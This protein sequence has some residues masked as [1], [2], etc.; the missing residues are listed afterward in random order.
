MVFF[1]SSPN[2]ATF[3]H[4]NPTLERIL[5]SAP[6]RVKGVNLGTCQREMTKSPGSLVSFYVLPSFVPFFWTLFSL[7]ENTQVEMV[8]NHQIHFQHL[9]TKVYNHSSTTFTRA[10]LKSKTCTAFRDDKVKNVNIEQG[11]IKIWKDAVNIHPNPITSTCHLLQKLLSAWSIWL[12]PSKRKLK[13][14]FKHI[15]YGDIHVRTTKLYYQSKSNQLNIHNAFTYS[16]WP[17]HR[18][19]LYQWNGNMF[20]WQ[21][22]RW[23]LCNI[24]LWPWNSTT[25]FQ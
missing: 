10:K 2:F 1:V 22:E 15:L 25:W 23:G 7:R 6:W 17:Q 13:G 21:S 16:N 14:Q 9:S 12:L 20:V 19:S 24:F 18:I 8:P 5:P 3:S 11:W 4:I